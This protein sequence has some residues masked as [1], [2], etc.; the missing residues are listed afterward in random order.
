MKRGLIVLLAILSLTLT[1]C[2]N[3][4][5]CSKNE[6]NIYVKLLK[7]DK[8]EQCLQ[9]VVLTESERKQ[10]LELLSLF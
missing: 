10:Y 3:K 9:S 2:A 5:A 6:L 1:A 4:Q 7:K 8:I